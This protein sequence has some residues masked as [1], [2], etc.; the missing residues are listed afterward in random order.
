[1]EERMS[2]GE[3]IGTAW[4]NLTGVNNESN[5]VRSIRLL[6]FIIFLGGA[7]WAGY[8]YFNY[9]KMQMEL[10][11]KIYTPSGAPAALETDRKRLK[12][13]VEQ[14]KATTEIRSNS[15]IMVQTME[16]GGRYAFADPVLFPPLKDDLTL[17]GKPAVEV[18]TPEII[19]MPPE[20]V[21]RA[22]MVMGRQQVAVMDIVGVGS[23]MIVRAGDT[24]MQKKGRIVRIAPDK[25]VMRWGGKNFDIRPNF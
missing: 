23:G 24:F 8:N 2:W 13:M 20:I 21:L 17:V 4:G 22:I 9:H 18:V 25:V 3:A 6:F 5:S 10:E 11:E 1:M 16:D 14:V 15:S 12:D 7:A 19:E